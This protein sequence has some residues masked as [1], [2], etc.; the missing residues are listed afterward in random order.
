[1]PFR[2]LRLRRTMDFA[3]HRTWVRR[4]TWSA[5]A[6]GA[7][8]LVG[9]GLSSAPMLATTSCD[10]QECNPSPAIDW[11]CPPGVPAATCCSHGYM[12]G[13]TWLSSPP[14]ELAS[15]P[16]AAD[17]LPYNANS[18]IRLYLAAWTPN[19]IPEP[20]SSSISIS[21]NPGP[22]NPD[23]KDDPPDAP[24][25]IWTT[26]SGNEAEW[27][28]MAP[29][30]AEVVNGTCSPWYVRISVVFDVPDGGL[31]KGPCWK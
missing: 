31:I 4:F 19:G 14:S 5:I 21:L 22:Q 26:G 16:D 7:V 1:M 15:S 30:Y 29:G 20:T 12:N 25:G 13:N 28:N 10:G 8:T 24:V 23:P 6:G 17:W 11:G 3:P 2:A 9:A 27:D 18:R